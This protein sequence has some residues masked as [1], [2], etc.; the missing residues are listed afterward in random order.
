MLQNAASKIVCFFVILSAWLSSLSG[1]EIQKNTISY[2]YEFAIAAIFQ[3]EAPYLKEWIEYH[4]IVGA[5]H[6]YLYNNQSNDH[7]LEVLS[8]YLQ[9]GTVELV[10]WNDPDF[11]HNGQKNGYRDAIQKCQ[12]KVKWLALIDLDE[13]FVPKFHNN[14]ADLLAEYNDKEIGGLCV[15]WQMFGTSNVA[16]INNGELLIEKLILK[17]PVDHNENLHVKSIVRPDYVVDPPHVHYF[18]YDKEHHQVN[19]RRET[20]SGS[21]SSYVLIDTLQLNHYWTK[22]EAFFYTTKIPRRLQWGDTMA[23][24][25]ERLTILNQVQDSAIQRF[26]PLL[27][28]K[29]FPIKQNFRGPLT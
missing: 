20:I 11:L 8:P 1:E 21:R 27:K 14:M 13:Y 26:V 6:F 16:K 7:Y 25:N 12:G 29:M 3:N 17:A 2:R 4:K 24:I 9:D 5:Q 22:D 10:D 15:N 23:I 18:E 19:T 28:S